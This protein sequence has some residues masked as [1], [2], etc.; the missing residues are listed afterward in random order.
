MAQEPPS[1]TQCIIGPT[2][3]LAKW[4]LNPLN[5]LSRKKYRQ[6]YREHTLHQ[7][8]IQIYLREGFDFTPTHEARRP[9][10]H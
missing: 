7:P 1:Q 3:V 8:H 9:G 2:G 5:S 6:K 10:E 4:H